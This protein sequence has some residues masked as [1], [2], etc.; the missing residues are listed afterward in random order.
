LPDFDQARAFGVRLER[1]REP[2]RAK[3]ARA[4]TVGAFHTV[5][6]PISRANSIVPS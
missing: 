3:V 5:V 1:A 6:V 2:H 4:T